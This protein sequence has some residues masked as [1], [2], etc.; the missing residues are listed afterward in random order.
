MKSIH[1][2]NPMQVGKVEVTKEAKLCLART[3]SQAKKA[4]AWLLPPVQ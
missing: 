2:G 4:G 3:R 1:L